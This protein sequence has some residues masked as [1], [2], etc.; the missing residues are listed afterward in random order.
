MKKLLFIAYILLFTLPVIGQQT[1][2]VLFLGNS[3][4][5]GNNLPQMVADIATSMGD[6]LIFDQNTPGGYTT[7]QHEQNATSIA[8]I[9]SGNWDHVVLQE[10]SYVGTVQWSRDNFSYPAILSLRSMTIKNDSCSDLL[11][12]MTWGRKNAFQGYVTDGSGNQYFSPAFTD[13]FHMQDSLETFYMNIANQE[14]IP[15]APV[16]MVWKKIRTYHPTYDLYTGDGSHAN[17]SGT[18]VAACTFYA[19]IF[20]KSPVGSTYLP[21]G[22]D[23]NMA[24]F[25]K[26]YT[27]TLVHQDYAQWNIDT[28]SIYAAFTV[29]TSALSV[30]FTNQSLNASNYYWDFGDGNTSTDENPTPRLRLQRNLYGYLEILC[31]L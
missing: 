9:N 20:H 1:K 17:V 11:L 25:I 30:D 3:Y 14:N 12:Y 6:T 2:K 19:S 13:Y 5:Y 15:V 31:A 21:S 10:Q 16:G 27:D 29:D 7:W 8:K 4:T 28:S 18:Y 23:P 22:V 26:A 24:D